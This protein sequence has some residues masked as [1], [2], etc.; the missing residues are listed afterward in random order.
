M[1]SNAVND[2]D[3]RPNPSTQF[4]S[5]PPIIDGSIPST[6]PVRDLSSGSLEGIGDTQLQQIYQKQLQ[7]YTPKHGDLVPELLT[8]APG[9][10]GLPDNNL[11][12]VVECLRKYLELT[13]KIR[14]TNDRLNRNWLL[15][16]FVKP[17]HPVTTSTLA[18]WLKSV[19]SSAGI[20]TANHKTHSTRS[21][22]TSKAFRAGD[23]SSETM[24]QARWSNLTT[25]SRFYC[26]PLAGSD[27]QKAVLIR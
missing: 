4:S 11:C 9:N 10:D 20:D 21:A 5:D 2:E 15:L 13:E 25:F 6:G 22:C 24:K 26:K 17:H 14:D 1:V 18:R 27:F 19:I 16:S 3:C 12:S 23:S 8:K 7:N